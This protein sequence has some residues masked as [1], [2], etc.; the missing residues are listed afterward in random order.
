MNLVQPI[1][2]KEM[3]KELKEYFKEQNERNYI[4]F[5]LGINTG[6]RISDILRLRVRDVEGWS[7]FIREKKTRKVKEVKM[8]SDL[9]KSLREYV[10]GK[11]KNEFLIKSRNGKNKPITRSMAYVILNQAAL[12]F[13]LERIGTH[14][15][16]KT[17]GYHHYKQFKDV[18][19]LQRMLNHTDQKETLRYIGIE[20]DTL[21]DYQKKFKI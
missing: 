12:K 8:P 11:P 16:R 19:V 14:S 4:L 20:Q 21:N 3:I 18:V 2:D 10:K 13:G 9:K 5:L 1:R 7:I 6:L 17:Y 15:L